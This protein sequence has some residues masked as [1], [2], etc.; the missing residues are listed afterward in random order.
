MDDT[1]EQERLQRVAADRAQKVARLRREY[2]DLTDEE[3]VSAV[4][5]TSETEM[6]PLVMTMRLIA[7]IGRLEKRLKWTE[8]LTWALV[9]LTVVLIVLTAAL[10]RSDESPTPSA[11]AIVTRP[12]V[13]TPGGM[14]ALI[15]GRLIYVFSGDCFVLVGGGRFPVMWPVGTRAVA[16]PGPGIIL[17]SGG[18]VRPGDLV[19]GAGGF[20]TA[21]QVSAV[22][23]TRPEIPDACTSSSGEI[24][25]FNHQTRPRVVR[26]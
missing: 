13:R 23:G 22:D 10:L 12:N 2:G 24:A 14:A 3:V 9:A 26:R 16:D 1:E 6:A 21:D 15:R 4:I 5:P 7:A 11:P 8:R 19:E 25:V 20:L 18:V 17:S